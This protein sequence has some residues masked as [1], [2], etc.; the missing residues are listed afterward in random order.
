MEVHE[1]VSLHLSSSLPATNI[2][3]VNLLVPSHTNL[4]PSTLECSLVS[5]MVAS[6]MVQAF[7]R[8]PPWTFMYKQKSSQT[9]STI[10]KLLLGMN[11]LLLCR[12]SFPPFIL[13]FPFS[14]FFYDSC[15]HSVVQWRCPNDSILDTRKCIHDLLVQRRYSQCPRQQREVHHLQWSDLV[16]HPAFLL[17]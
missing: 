5:P 1:E 15:R 10:I 2:H 11:S 13:L 14:C 7:T 12:Y 6:L 4:Q 16:H 8:P 3:I 9:T 17:W